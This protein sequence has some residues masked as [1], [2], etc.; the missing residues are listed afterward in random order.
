MI[1]W[2]RFYPIYHFY[3][4]FLEYSFVP[5]GDHFNRRLSID[6]NRDSHTF[7]PAGRDIYPVDPWKQTIAVALP[8]Q[9]CVAGRKVPDPGDGAETRR[10][11]RISDVS[12]LGVSARS[13]LFR[14]HWT[15][16]IARRTVVAFRTRRWNTP[17]ALTD[18]L[19]RYR[20]QQ[21]RRGGCLDGLARDRQ[22]ESYPSA[23]ENRLGFLRVRSR[24][25]PSS[26]HRCLSVPHLATT[27]RTRIGIILRSDDSST[28]ETLV[29]RFLVGRLRDISH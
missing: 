5:A 16:R 25:V 23:V 8:F 19:A 17:V 11:S 3:I 6:G 20:C 4:K 29:R 14:Q 1:L 9:Q 2:D 10:S 21:R 15:T 12:Q 26:L 27:V 13:V 22:T 24:P 18:D 7:A 28:L